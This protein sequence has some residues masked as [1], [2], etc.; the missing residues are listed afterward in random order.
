VIGY[1]FEVLFAKELQNRYPDD[2][3]GNLTEDEKDLVCIKQP[4]LS[5]EIKSSGQLGDRVYGNRSY[6]QKVVNTELAKKEKSGFY[7]TANF[8]RRTLTL[9]RFGW[10][11]ASDWKSQK[12][13]TGQ[14]A[15]LPDSVYQHKLVLI[16]GDYRLDAPVDFLN[17]VGRKTAERFKAMGICTIRELLRYRGEFPHKSMQAIQAAAKKEYKSTA[18]SSLEE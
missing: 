5:V 9:L 12:S 13:P 14:M 18:N 4:N 7:I 15:G 10:I 2:W 3:R 6:G 11:D 8:F 1:F 17:G 16:D